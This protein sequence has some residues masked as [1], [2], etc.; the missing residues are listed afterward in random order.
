MNLPLRRPQTAQP[1]YPGRTIT[2]LILRALVPIPCIWPI[3]PMLP[4]LAGP[5]SPN[6]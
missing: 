1:G 2:N 3:H 6:A 4:I 5:T